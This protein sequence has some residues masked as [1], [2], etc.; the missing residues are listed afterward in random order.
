MYIDTHYPII[1]LIIKYITHINKPLTN[2]PP[3]KKKILPH[4]SEHHAQPYPANNLSSFSTQTGHWITI[5]EATSKYT[6]TN[7]I[8]MH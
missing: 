8:N 2:P 1:D 4:T 3:P 7:K 5:G 6:G